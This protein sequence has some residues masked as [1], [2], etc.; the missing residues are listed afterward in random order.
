MRQ[1]LLPILGFLVLSSTA[2][3]QDAFV[4]ADVA[5]GDL[6]PRQTELLH[7]LQSMQ[8]F[9]AAE[10]V[11]VN[12]DALYGQEADLRLSSASSLTMTRT[13]LE[14]NI[15][16]DVA[17]YTWYGRGQSV[18][19]HAIL[20]VRGD[21]ATGTI[22]DGGNLYFV[23]PLTGG[24][25]VVAKIN[26]NEFVDHDA[27]FEQIEDNSAIFYEN[28]DVNSILEASSQASGGSEIIYIIVGYT[29][30]AASEVGDIDALVLLA[31]AETNTSYDNSNVQPDVALAHKFEL[32]QNESGSFSTDL[33]RLIATSDGWYDE[34][35]PLRD[36]HGGDV[37]V[38][39]TG[40][41]GGL[42]G[43]ASSILASSDSQA[44][45]VASQTCATGYYT[46]G[47]EVGHLQGARHNPETDPNT[48]PFAYGHGKYETSDSWRTVMSY[49]CPGGC[50]RVTQW[51]NPDVDYLGTPT[52]DITTRD[53][54]RV[55]DETAD[56]IAGFRPDPVP[57]ELVSFDGILN[58]GVV[59]LTWETSSETNNSGFEIQRLIGSDWTA[60]GFVSGYGTTTEAHSYN[61]TDSNLSEAVSHLTYRL[62]QIDYDGAFEYSP[63]V[64][65]TVG[66]PDSF[67]L[68]NAYPNPFNPATTVSFSLP[69]SANVVVEVF[70]M[71][72]R[73]VET[74]VN[75]SLDEGFHSTV[76][77]ASNAPSG[78]YL[79]RM[80]AN[81]H[82]TTQQVTLL[83]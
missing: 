73:K 79:V 27:S 17:S 64:E 56:Y 1:F 66:A 30:T 12:L 81:G 52:G 60:L 49:N 44:F 40:N 34:V 9:V 43:L 36:T 80:S 28:N 48:S 31:I 16:E 39:I 18:G 69:A 4:P 38:M 7:H 22:R 11:T 58:N 8:Q 32:A 10:L 55:L 53:N 62:K 78:L 46:F 13:Q 24:L 14:Q 70:D 74:L 50:T 54:A 2:F 45:A 59:Q 26:E 68:L 25:H 15:R 42:C 21:M 23:R 65:I 57:V 51:S 72:G 82:T 63:E 29:P 76:W 37:G 83:K 77:D 41:N 47:H 75:T 71:L 20:V 3:S 19:T 61:F 5:A 33:N 6:N 35:H 67:T